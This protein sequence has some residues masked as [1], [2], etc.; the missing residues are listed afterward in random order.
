MDFTLS[1]PPFLEFPQFGIFAKQPVGSIT[2]T[3]DVVS[4]PIECKTGIF[5]GTACIYSFIEQ[6]RNLFS[7]DGTCYGNTAALPA[8]STSTLAAHS[9]FSWTPETCKTFPDLA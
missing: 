2:A 4:Q 3:D 9:L 6:S 7:P 5:F 8:S 1:S